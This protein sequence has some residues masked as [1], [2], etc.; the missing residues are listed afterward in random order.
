VLDFSAQTTWLILGLFTLS[1]AF[2]TIAWYG[3]LRFKLP[4]VMAIIVGWLIALCEYVVMIPTIRTAFKDGFDLIQIKALQEVLS[5]LVFVIFA[6]FFLKERLGWRHI[7][8]FALMA[9]GLYMLFGV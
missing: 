8:G 3:H 7:V 5:I 2:M 1:G 4:L 6:T 9:S